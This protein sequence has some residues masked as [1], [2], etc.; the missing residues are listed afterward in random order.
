MAHARCLSC[1][2]KPMSARGL[3]RSCYERARQSGVHRQYPD[4]GAVPVPY[5]HYQQ[6]DGCLSCGAL[7]HVG[8]GL[9]HT[10]YERASLT[11]G[12]L[13]Q[14]PACGAVPVPYRGYGYRK[15]VPPHLK[16]SPDQ[17]AIIGAPQQP[18]WQAC[19]AWESRPQRWTTLRPAERRSA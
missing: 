19:V 10:C 18:D 14:Y 13:D 7:D 9:C 12:L 3:C 6:H 1:G 5:R 17:P 11:P 2:T 15:M 4:C 8:R 16:Q